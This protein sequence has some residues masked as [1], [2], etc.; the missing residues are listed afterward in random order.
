MGVVD[1][2]TRVELARQNARLIVELDHARIDAM[3]LER[4]RERAE[5]AEARLELTQRRLAAAMR[6]FA[7]IGRMS[8]WAAALVERGRAEVFGE[9]P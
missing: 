8:P 2:P 7:S 5:R 4:W 6:V 9:L 1:I 3:E